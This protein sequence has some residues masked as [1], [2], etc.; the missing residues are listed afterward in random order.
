[1]KHAST[2]GINFTS[3]TIFQIKAFSNKIFNRHT[4]YR[5]LPILFF[6]LKN[7]ILTYFPNMLHSDSLEIL[8]YP[9]DTLFQTS[10]FSSTY[11]ITHISTMPF[12]SFSFLSEQNILK[13]YRHIGKI[14]FSHSGGGLVCYSAWICQKCSLWCAL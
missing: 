4:N 8:Q 12:G 5:S 3:S 10:T 9:D 2:L 6:N 7:T 13:L 1:M 11:L 14:K